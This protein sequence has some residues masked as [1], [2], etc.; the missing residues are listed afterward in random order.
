MQRYERNGLLPA[1]F[2]GSEQVVVAVR[3]SG[4]NLGEV[5][6][7]SWFTDLDARAQRT[8]IEFAGLVAEV[9]AAATG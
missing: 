2:A 4:I 9:G 5:L 1:V 6:A 7:R 3:A 8:G